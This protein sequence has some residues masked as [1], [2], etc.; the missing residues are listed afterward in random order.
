MPTAKGSIRNEPV[1]AMSYNIWVKG[2]KLGIEKKQLIDSISITET[3]EGADTAIINLKDPEFN[4]I[5]DTIFVEDAQIKIQMIWSGATYKITFN[6]YI[7][8]IDISFGSDGIPV[9]EILCMDK[10]RLMNRKK[11]NK[12]YKNI[13]SSNLVKKIV[14]SYGFK[15]KGESGYKFEKQES[16]SQ[17]NQTDINFITQLASAEVYP[18]TARLIGNTFYYVKKG[19]LAESKMTLHYN[20]HPY[21]V[22]N[23]N[24]QVNNETLQKEQSTSK[25]SGKK[26]KTSKGKVKNKKTSDKASSGKSGSKTG[27][28]G[29][30]KSSSHNTKKSGTKTYNPKTRKWS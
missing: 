29:K 16:I 12:V 17:S 15:F 4:F 26:K 3:V 14:K 20:E 23:L 22:I 25:T 13:T 18:F 10:S 30:N 11:K 6:G 27:S 28:N 1:L 5:D 7:S 2:T 9:L 24:F 21:E 19:K 8:A